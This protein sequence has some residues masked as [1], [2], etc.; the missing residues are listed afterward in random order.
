MPKNMGS[1]VAQSTSSQDYKAFSRVLGVTQPV[2]AGYASHHCPKLSAL[3]S[4]GALHCG[5]EK[6][7]VVSWGSPSRW[8]LAMSGS[9]APKYRV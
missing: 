6:R 8:A 1:D 9:V 7:S 4:L 5:F 3:T 2:G